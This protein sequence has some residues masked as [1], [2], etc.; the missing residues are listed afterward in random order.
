MFCRAFLSGS[1]LPPGPHNLS[2]QTNRALASSLLRMPNR[3]F[4]PQ[5]AG[6]RLA[7]RWETNTANG[8]T[9]AQHAA[10]RAMKTQNPE[11][12]GTSLER[13]PGTAAIMMLSGITLM[14][15]FAGV[16]L[17]YRNPVTM[18]FFHDYVQTMIAATGTV[19]FPSGPS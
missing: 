15:T 10:E 3:R 11:T 14:M 13:S 2:C 9:V 5:L 19:L 8:K 7:S 6:A 4:S 18:A 16:V 12:D 17:A 1:T